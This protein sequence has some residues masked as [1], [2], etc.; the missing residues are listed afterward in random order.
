MPGGVGVSVL[1]TSPVVEGST[2]AEALRN[3]VDLAVLADRLGYRRYWA[4]ENHGMRGVASCAPAVLTAELA[5][6]TRRIRVGAGGVLLPHHAPL[7]VAEQFGTLEALHPQRI[8][9]GL[10]RAT[11]APRR[12]APHLR[13]EH[14]RPFDEQLTALLRW[15]D[16]DSAAMPAA[17]NRPELWVLG[18]SVAT[19]GTAARLGLPYATRAEADPDTAVTVLAAADG[20]PTMLETPVIA[21]PTDAEAERVAASVRAR[22]AWRSRHG[23]RVRLPDVATA[24][25]ALADPDDRAEGHRL[26][27]HHV[28]GGPDTVRERLQEL[29]D[30]TGADELMV[31]GYVADHDDRCRSYEIIADVARGLRARV[32]SAPSRG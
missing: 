10:G 19:A 9:L 8:D 31:S 13:T 20:V 24:V 27:R 25:T 6:R 5:G 30:R 16:E 29:L 1:D 18:S 22:L 28:V 4:A 3:T 32:L 11:G 14:D 17:G 2:A 15:F 7:V 26:T 12:I 23:R 21:A